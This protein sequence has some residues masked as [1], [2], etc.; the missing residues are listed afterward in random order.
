M[1]HDVHTTFICRG[2][3]WSGEIGRGSFKRR[4]ICV[5]FYDLLL[6]LGVREPLGYLVGGAEDFLLQRKKY[7]GGRFLVN[8]GTFF[9]ASVL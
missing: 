8:I 9:S 4:A 7:S 6:T 5:M 3:E 1:E 2:A